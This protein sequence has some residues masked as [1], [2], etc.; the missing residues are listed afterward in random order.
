MTFHICQAEAVVRIRVPGVQI[1][2]KRTAVPERVVEAAIKSL[3]QMLSSARLAE[4]FHQATEY[5]SCLVNMADPY[6]S[7]MHVDVL[8]L[9]RQPD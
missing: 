4:V 7:P 8:A 3:A 9:I 5:S 2:H 1:P 6:L